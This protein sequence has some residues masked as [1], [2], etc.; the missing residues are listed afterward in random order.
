MLTNQPVRYH[1]RGGQR[2][3]GSVVIQGAKNAALPLIAASLL[4][5]KGQTILHNVPLIS[6][7]YVAIEIARSLGAKIKLHEEEQILVIDATTLTSSVL[8]ADLTNMIRASI[9]FIPPLM[10]RM[11]SASIEQVGGC[12]L[13]QR[14]L[15]FHYRG[16][17]RLGAE[18]VDNE[19]GGMSIH[20]KQAKGNYLYLDMP[21]HTGTE[22]LI[23][24]A[25]MAEGT[26]II[27]NAAMEPEIA[28][29]ANFLNLMGAKIAGVGSA[30]LHIEGVKEL[31]AVEYTIM[32]DRIDAGTM[33]MLAAATQGDVALIGGRLSHFG[34]VRAKLEQMGVEFMEDGPV[35]RV[36]RRGELRPVN[37]ITWPYPGYPTD[38]QPQLMAL[39]S[40]A[41]GTSYIRENLFDQRFGA[42]QELNKMGANIEIKNGSAIVTGPTPLSGTTVWAHDLRAGGAL[43][44]AGAAAEGNTIIDNAQ[45]IER[46]YTA[47]LRRLSNLGMDV[48]IEQ[49][50]EEITLASAS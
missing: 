23:T 49:I 19:A 6:D 33:A 1:V 15:D 22:N 18:V 30:V 20:M 39:S 10:I 13:G 42:A 14:N 31:S 4:A 37:I 8:P 26:T 43:L 45:M 28:N 7:V 48:Q 2:L 40:L 25:C 38:L 47:L 32:P 9:L 34:I 17:A 29:V 5:S 21:S 11:G 46:G 35:I 44:I 36:R 12:N 16:F 24:A 27:E 41:N 3:E 50:V